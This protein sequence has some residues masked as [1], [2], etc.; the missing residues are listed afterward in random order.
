MDE[1]DHKQIIDIIEFPEE[2]DEKIY[3]LQKIVY[4]NHPVYRDREK[5]LKFWHWWFREPAWGKGR[6]FGV[7]GDGCIAGVRPL[8]FLPVIINGQGGLCGVLNATVTHPDYRKRGFFT[9]TLN[10]VLDIA[11]KEEGLRFLISFPNEMSYPLHLKN[12]RM[13]VLC[14]LPLY[15]KVFRPKAFFKRKLFLPDAGAKAIVNMFQRTK[16]RAF[17]EGYIVKETEVFDNRFDRLWERAMNNHKIW[18]QRTAQYLRWRYG[19]SPLGPYTVLI[20]EKC[21]SGELAGY[22]IAKLESRFGIELGLILDILMLPEEIN[23]ASALVGKCLAL[24]EE[25]GADAVGC[26]M[27][28]HQPEISCLHDN[29]MWNLPHWLYPKKFHVTM[30]ALSREKAF[31]DFILDANNWYLTWGDTDNV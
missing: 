15:I 17:S 30:A 20:A 12:N 2:D 27:L 8:S 11:E 13:A 4:P 6:V 1:K 5:S 25:R 7:M 3:K 22:V 26:L 10:H 21:Q 29:G 19:Q 16:S 31:N 23:G 14:D 24:M 9:S 18:I 28:R